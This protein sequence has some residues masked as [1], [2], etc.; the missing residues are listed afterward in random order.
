[1]A[2]NP[3]QSTRPL[4]GATST[5]VSTVKLDNVSI[6]A[7]LARRDPK[8]DNP[9]GRLCV[10]IHAPLAR[11][12]GGSSGLQITRLVSIHAPLAR[13]DTLF[14]LMCPVVRRFNPRAPCE[15]RLFT[16]LTKYQNVIRF[17]STR[18]LRGA[19][20]TILKAF[21]IAFVS[22]HAPLARRDTTITGA[23][24]MAGV[25]IHAPLARRD[26]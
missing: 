7:P 5:V 22:I 25:S 20:I 3:F 23:N 4:R 26:I 18:P 2:V 14:C 24:R 8:D 17:Q 13:R 9:R 10:S 16:S 21:L 11:R 12:D 19:T 15:A 6:H 1:M